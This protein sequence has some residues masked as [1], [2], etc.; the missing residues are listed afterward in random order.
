MPCDIG[1]KN[2]SRVSIPA[3]QPLE[4]RSRHEAPKVDAE[5]MARIGRDDPGFVA[6]L[7]ELDTGPLLAEALKRTLAALPPG[8]LKFS[9][10][11]GGLAASA[12]FTSQAQKRTLEEKADKI[13]RRW[14][15]EVLKIVLTL[16]GYETRI[17]AA[18]EL[19]M[20]EAEKHGGGRQVHEY[21]RVTMDPAQGASVMFEH[22][23]SK[24]E[25][26]ADRDKFRAL[27][28]KLGV[29]IR[30]VE[31]RESGSPIPEGTEHK[32]FLKRR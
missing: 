23:A 14:Q 25:L 8:K 26:E 22:F 11:N 31:S 19:L 2:F 15:M 29:P 4:F 13:G 30:V 12:T 7:Q 21:V 6:W 28:Q 10:E 24:K 16:L 32:H 1:Y 27:S 3:P 18:G 17:T 9:I 5:L 20:L